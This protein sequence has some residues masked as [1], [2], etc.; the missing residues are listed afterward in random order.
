MRI[1]AF[2]FVGVLLLSSVRDA[3]GQPASSVTAE[4]VV[5]RSGTLRL[6]GLLSKPP[7]PGTF[8]AVL[9]NHGA[10]PTDTA[11]GEVL[12]PV[13]AK[14]GYVFLYLFRRG[15][16]PSASQGEYM[17]DA[18][19][20]EENAHGEAARKRLQ[21]RLLTTD[22]LD[23]AMAGLAFLKRLPGVDARRIAVAGHSFGG[24]LTLL[25]VERDKDVRAAV[26]FGAAAQSWDGSPDLQ[27]WLL[28]AARNIQTPI[29]L[30]HAAND[31]SIVPGQMLSAEL[32]RRKR[33][34]ELKIYPAVGD[35]PR[36]GHQAVYT[37]IPTWER[38]VFSFLDK[39][40]RSRYFD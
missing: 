25:A 9:F 23:D 36:D 8:P 6:T 7:G 18:L 17:R 4:R 32:T 13:F 24:Q 26:T 3:V 11:R 22:H 35:T 34:H 29:F 15:H 30:T 10:G 31:F 20:R 40:L 5:V 14:H 21:L 38:D 12:G 16:G 27:Q 19:D 39:Y 2:A 33:P 28:K 37:D 1:A